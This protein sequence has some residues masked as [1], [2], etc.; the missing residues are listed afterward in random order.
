MRKSTLLRELLDLH[1][2]WY[3]IGGKRYEHLVLVGDP[4]DLPKDHVCRTTG[5]EACSE[6][7]E[8]HYVPACT[9]CRSTTDDGDPG[10]PLWPCATARLAME[11]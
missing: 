8:E 3:E 9:E 7:F 5:D 2:P 11:A 10:Y 1:K 6:D 4:D